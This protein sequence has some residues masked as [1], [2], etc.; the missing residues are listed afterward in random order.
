[1]NSKSAINFTVSFRAWDE[2]SLMRSLALFP[3]YPDW[4]S[5]KNRENVSEFGHQDQ[6]RSDRKVLIEAI[7]ALMILPE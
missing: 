5:L 3:N 4:T 6:I 7:Q 1:M 2:P